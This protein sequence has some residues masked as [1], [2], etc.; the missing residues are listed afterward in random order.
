M[1]LGDSS[2]GGQEGAGQEGLG[3]SIQALSVLFYADN[4]LIASP[5]SARLQGAFKSLTG[6][7]E[8]NGP[9]DQLGKDSAYWQL[10]LISYTYYHF[11]YFFQIVSIC[12][13]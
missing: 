13:G 12:H 6:L 7:F 4:G 5:K 10:L 9:P 2:G 3:M 1:T 8:P 11:Y